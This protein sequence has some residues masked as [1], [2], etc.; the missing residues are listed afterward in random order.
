[1]YLQSH[2]PVATYDIDSLF[3]N[4]CLEN[5]SEYFRTAVCETIQYTFYYPSVHKQ[6]TADPKY[7]EPFLRHTLYL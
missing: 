4:V 1:M 7:S 3:Y 6:E 5:D 2:I